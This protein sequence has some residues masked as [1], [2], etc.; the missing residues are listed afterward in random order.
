L[1]RYLQQH[2][3]VIP[4]GFGQKGIHYFDTNYRRGPR[5]YRSHFPTTS[6]KAHRA[7]RLG[8]PVITG[9]GSPY[10]VF[11]PLAPQRIAQTVPDA[12]FI[13]MLRD[14]VSRA[15]SHYQHEVARG[16]EDLEFED[17]LDR[18]DER[19]AGERERLLADPDYNSFAYQHFSYMARGLYLE[20]IRR[21]HDLV[22]R[23]RL[24]IVDSAEFFADPDASF[25]EILRFLDLPPRSLG[26]YRKMNA[27][28]Y[29]RMSPAAREMLASRFAAP[30]A[31]LS[32][33]LGRAFSWDLGASTS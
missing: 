13:L 23:D 30:N 32:R 25:Q 9:E 6:F 24:L 5:W 19:L 18:E 29:G 17:A 7:R 10:Y 2:P 22:P 16:F 8:G 20:Q 11:H 12:R 33:Y 28:D 3:H 26:A 27:H 4:V 1:Y 31:E 15:Y 14:P 21:W